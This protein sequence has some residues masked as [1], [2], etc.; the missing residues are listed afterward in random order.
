[1]AHRN[2]VDQK[3]AKFEH[4]SAQAAGAM[5][6]VEIARADDAEV[7]VAAGL[8]PAARYARSALI[9]STKLITRTFP[10]FAGICLSVAK[11]SLGASLAPAPSTNDR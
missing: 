11:S 10:V 5:V 3:A 9:K 1:M 6:R 8:C 4:A 2:Q 7:V